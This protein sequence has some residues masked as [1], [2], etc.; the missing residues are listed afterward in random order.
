MTARISFRKV[1]KRS[2]R[3]IFLALKNSGSC[4][5]CE[6][7]TLHNLPLFIVYMFVD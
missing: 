3:D 6:I 1:N 2:E 5:W 4:V 7:Q